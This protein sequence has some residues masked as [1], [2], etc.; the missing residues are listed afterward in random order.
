M[1]TIIALSV[2]MSNALI[3]HVVNGAETA[4]ATG[5]AALAETSIRAIAAIL[6]SKFVLDFTLEDTFYSLLAG[7]N[8]VG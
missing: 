2:N 3:S 5:N 6:D 1:G 7:L 8:M 4:I